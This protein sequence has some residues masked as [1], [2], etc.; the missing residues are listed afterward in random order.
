MRAEPPPSRATRARAVWSESD[1]AFP[2]PP[3]CG[4]AVRAAVRSDRPAPSRYTHAVATSAVVTH[5]TRLALCR[6]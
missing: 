4:A 6:I 5:A 2:V 3:G 1:H